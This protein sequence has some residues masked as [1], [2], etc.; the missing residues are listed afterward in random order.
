MSEMAFISI[1]DLVV[2]IEDDEFRKKMGTAMEMMGGTKFILDGYAA[3]RL[4]KA[5]GNTRRYPQRT[6]AG[7][8]RM[9]VSDPVYLNFECSI[10]FGEAIAG[11]QRLS[12]ER[13]PREE[14]LLRRCSHSVPMPGC[15]SCLR[16][17][18]YESGVVKSIRRPPV[19][20]GVESARESD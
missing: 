11:L 7:R 10:S 20:V 13:G 17:A 9:R 16:K 3:K 12:K 2:E 5:N 14:G 8:L 18:M 19:P 1:V 6:L 15:Q 4:L